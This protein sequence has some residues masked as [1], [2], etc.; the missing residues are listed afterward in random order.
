M[1][2]RHQTPV[3]VKLMAVV[4]VKLVSTVAVAVAVV[5]VGLVSGLA[6]DRGTPAARNWGMRHGQGMPPASLISDRTSLVQPRRPALRRRRDQTLRPRRRP[7]TCKASR[8]WGR[9]GARQFHS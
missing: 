5:A 9:V 2:A 7:Q 1:P 4:A 8:C 6:L 3:A